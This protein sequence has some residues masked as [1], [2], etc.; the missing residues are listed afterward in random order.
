MP[1]E[2]LVSY[3]IDLSYKGSIE[4]ALVL[5]SFSVCP[6]SK[7]YESLKRKL[8]SGHKNIGGVKRGD[9]T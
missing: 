2:A 6:V 3:K 5:G 1:N 9:I 7:H 4:S 8:I